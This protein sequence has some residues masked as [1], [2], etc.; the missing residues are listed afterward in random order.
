M[1]NNKLNNFDIGTLNYFITRAFL[2]GYLFHSLLKLI[3]QDSWIIPLIGFIFGIVFIVLVTYIFN[4]KPKINLPEKL[5]S[6]F[7]KPIGTTFVVIFCLFCF[8]MCVLT[9]LNI[10]NFIQGQFLSKTPTEVISFVLI[11]SVL[12]IL[13]KGINTIGRTGNI[14]FFIAMILFFVS[15]IGLLP[16][17][18][19]EN[20]KPFI[21]ENPSNYLKSLDCFYAF[22][23][24]PILFLTIIPKDSIN[25]PKLKKTL[26]F[27][28]LLSVI[29][30]FCVMFAT[31]SSFGFE[32]ASLYKYPEFHVL[33]NISLMGLEARI[34]S[35]LIIQCIFDFF[36]FITLSI[37]FI[38]N[39]IKSITNLKNLNILYTILCIL[40]V[41]ITNYF[42]K[43]NVYLGDFALKYVHWPV[44]IFSTIFISIVCIM[45]KIKKRKQFKSLS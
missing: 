21:N 39:S 44:T 38:A 25:K 14:L 26:F 7:G 27:S 11:L 42:S 22:N 31:I 5:V 4:Y 37:Y 43:Y 28:F 29:T 10:N 8:F 19:F 6:L 1:I 36:M 9:Y 2:T 41:L 17:M 12:Y 34:E 20:L 30:M 45:I 13:T 32:L 33:K 16:F 40:L 24:T 23:I 18:E 35:I 15:F 3:K